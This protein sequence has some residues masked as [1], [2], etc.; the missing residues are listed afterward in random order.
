MVRSVGGD[1]GSEG[2]YE[3]SA[4]RV[5]G[6]RGNRERAFAIEEQRNPRN[7]AGTYGDMRIA[8]SPPP[9][10]A[11]YRNLRHIRLQQPRHLRVDLL[12]VGQKFLLY[13]PRTYKGSNRHIRNRKFS[14]KIVEKYPTQKAAARI[15]CLTTERPNR[16][17]VSSGISWRVAQEAGRRRYW[18][19]T[20]MT[21]C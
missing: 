11:D 7:R 16:R 20:T 13:F 21:T 4:P 1:S 3:D 18:P 5:T 19:K 12:R 8:V 10:F 15:H 14:K 6:E 17:R 2:E 9:S